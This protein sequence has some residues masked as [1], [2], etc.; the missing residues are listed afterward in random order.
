[1]AVRNKAIDISL[2]HSLSELNVANKG[3]FCKCFAAMVQ[4]ELHT[5][6][7]SV[8]Q[9]GAYCRVQGVPARHFSSATARRLFDC[10]GTAC[11]AV[12]AIASEAMICRHFI[13]LEVEIV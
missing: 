2:Q 8:P 6:L 1:V 3:G 11:T 13:L 5:V 10:V 12:P 7:P 4:L 9:T